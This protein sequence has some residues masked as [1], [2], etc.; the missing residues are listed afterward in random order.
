M[1]RILFLSAAVLLCSVTGSMA[2]PK[3]TVIKLN[4]TCDTFDVTISG[5]TVTATD[6]P[7]CAA[8]Y[9]GGLV[10]SVKGFGKT[11]V[12]ALHDPSQPGVQFVLELAYPFLQGG[13]YTLYQTTNGNSLTDEIDGT[14]TVE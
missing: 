10:G 5:A 7:S 3:L 1:K 6:A 9:G 8:T 11:V 13:A 2:K 14:Y 4:E 12:L